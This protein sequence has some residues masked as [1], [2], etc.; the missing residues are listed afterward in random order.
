M[1]PEARECCLGHSDEHYLIHWSSPR[2]E[3]N[4][5]RRVVFLLIY[6]FD[7]NVQSLQDQVI[8]GDRVVHRSHTIARHSNS[9][10]GCPANMEARRRGDD[11][12]I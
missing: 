2:R 1:N 6:F 12:H 8:R 5:T 11:E 9:I 3:I 7:R 10:S 4:D